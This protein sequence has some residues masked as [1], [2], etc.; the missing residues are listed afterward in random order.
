M[1]NQGR[2]IGRHHLALYRGWL[3]GISLKT[4]A[5]RYLETGLDLRL[6]KTTLTWIG[7]TI[8]QAALRNGKHG[9]ARLLRLSLST[10]EAPCETEVPTLE[11]FQAER[12]PGGFYNEDELIRL[13]LE[14]FPQAIDKKS[15]QRQRLI[16][17]QIEA[18]LWVEQLLA[19]DP[20][21]ADLVSAWFDEVVANRLILADIP[22]IGALLDRIRRKGYRWWITVPKL[23]EKGASRIIQWLRGYELALGA[24][25]DHALSPLRTLG[26]PALLEQRITQTAIV[27]IEALAVPDAIDGATGSNRWPGVPRISAINDHQAVQ[28]WLATKSGN[29]NTLR[30]YRKEAERMLLWAVIERGKALSDLTVDDCTHYRNWL[31]LLGRTDSSEWKFK[32]DQSA[33]I[34]PRNT[35]RFS[36]A[37][38]PFDGALSASSVKHSITIVGGLFEWL[39]RVQYCAFNPWDGV[40]KTLAMSHE[41]PDDIE[42]TRVFSEGQWEFL[43]GHLASMTP[44]DHT[45]RLQF[46][47]PFAHAT[48]LR[49]SELVDAKIGRFYSMPV[50]DGTN[51]R[52]MLKVLGKGAK[53]RAVP[54]PERIL[55]LLSNYLAHRKLDLD[56]L[57]NSAD[58]PLLARINGIDPISPSGL[59]KA[60]RGF[61]QDAALSLHA[62][63]KKH[64]ATA[65]ERASVHWL[66]HTC[67]SHMGSSGVPVNLIQKLLGHA[68]VATTS[69]YTESDSERLWLEIAD[70]ETKRAD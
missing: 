8:R 29:T 48:G 21:P 47:L 18:L 14:S 41:V 24:L 58:T 54:I 39:V 17:R 28:A 20:V 4:L 38:R 16:S 7:D 31:S 34:A 49:L 5:D 57:S 52:W 23:G 37:W 60:L 35:Q 1:A 43:M 26:M 53:W 56:P 10:T 33:W 13:F 45:Q 22:S 70:L 32:V 3:Q 64:E 11:D 9:E 59:Y 67:G 61:F 44:S 68:S 69:I 15:R 19:T 51:V 25:P 30:A 55:A 42:L 46:A 36:P 63:G 6:A 62:Q 12:D 40:G 27:P 50:R 2:K 65:F 66:R